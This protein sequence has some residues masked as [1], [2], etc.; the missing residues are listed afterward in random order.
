MKAGAGKHFESKVKSYIY[1]VD[2]FKFY[3]YRADIFFSPEIVSGMAKL[4]LL[5]KIEVVN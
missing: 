5:L 3:F 1:N 4:F 2:E